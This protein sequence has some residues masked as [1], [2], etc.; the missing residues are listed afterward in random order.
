MLIQHFQTAVFSGDFDLDNIKHNISSQRFNFIIKS[1]RIQDSFRNCKVRIN[2]VEDL[3]S[4]TG[5][6]GERLRE[7]GINI[8]KKMSG[9]MQGMTKR[10]LF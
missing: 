3:G 7:S 1:Q 4:V 5:I 6:L 9:R 2:I 8:T 10:K